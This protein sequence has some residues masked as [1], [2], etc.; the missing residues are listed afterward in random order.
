MRLAGIDTEVQSNDK[1]FYTNKQ[2]KGGTGF[3]ACAGW[4]EAGTE[5]R[6]T[7]PIPYV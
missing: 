4:P 5:A 7:N 6:P 3:P 2:S 1:C